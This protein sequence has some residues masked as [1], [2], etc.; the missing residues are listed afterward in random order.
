[1]LVTTTPTQGRMKVKELLDRIDQ[2][3]DRALVRSFAGLET[4]AKW[5]L[6]VVSW[7]LVVVAVQSVVRCTPSMTGLGTWIPMVAKYVLLIYV[8]MSLVSQRLRSRFG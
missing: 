3:R 1:M 8:L 5:L 6:T 2:A 7:L 4:I